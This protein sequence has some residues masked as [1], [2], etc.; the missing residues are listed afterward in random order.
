MNDKGYIGTYKGCSLF[1]LKNSYDWK[2]STP[3]NIKTY[4]SSADIFFVPAG[5]ES[6]LKI[7]QRG[8]L[9]SLEGNTVS[10]GRVNTRYDLEFGAVVVP[11]LERNIGYLYQT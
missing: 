4:W 9:T 7:I 10:N 5:L 8:D 2:N 3:G 6:P 11:E 1:A